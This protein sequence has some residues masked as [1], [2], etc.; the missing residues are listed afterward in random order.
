MLILDDKEVEL[1]YVYANKE[2][3][4]ESSGG[5]LCDHYYV[6]CP[7]CGYHDTDGEELENVN[8]GY[9]LLDDLITHH[10]SCEFYEYK[11]VLAKLADNIK[12]H[13][14]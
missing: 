14:K 5:T 1:L 11:A 3:R 10:P 9:K 7:C 12:S 8:N 6:V 4:V 2:L 13:R